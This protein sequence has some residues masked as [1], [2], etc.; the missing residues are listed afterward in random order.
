MH[1]SAS[2][3]DIARGVGIV[4]RDQIQGRVTRR[5]FVARLASAASVGGFAM[6]LSA[7]GGADPSTAPTAKPAEAPKPTEAPKPAA[8]PAGA[9]SPA[10]GASPATAASP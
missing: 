10:A 2:D 8:S 6:L 4:E 3:G 9:A 5:R 1:L 7:C